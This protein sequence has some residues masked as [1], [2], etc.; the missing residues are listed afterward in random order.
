[1][2]ALKVFER[3]PKVELTREQKSDTHRAGAMGAANWGLGTASMLAVP[4]MFLSP[5]FP[6][7]SW[8]FIAGTVLSGAIGLGGIGFVK[9]SERKHRRGTH[10]IAP[11]RTSNYGRWLDKQVEE[12]MGTICG[13]DSRHSALDRGLV[14]EFHGCGRDSRDHIY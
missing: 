13:S 4:T 9:V 2:T 12:D 11:I 3:K 8:A 10:S 6:E 7:L 14:E 1:M 5:L